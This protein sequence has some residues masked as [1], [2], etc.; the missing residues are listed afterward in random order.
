MHFSKKFSVSFAC[1]NCS[2]VFGKRVFLKKHN[3]EVHGGTFTFDCLVCN[4][5][6]ASRPE[7]TSHIKHCEAERKLKTFFETGHTCR[8]CGN[9]MPTIDALVSHFEN[10]HPELKPFQCFKCGDEFST[11]EVMKFHDCNKSCICDTCGKE[12]ANKSLL[13]RHHDR[14][15]DKLKRNKRFTCTHCDKEFRW[16]NSLIL[17]MMNHEGTKPSKLKSSLKKS[18]LIKSS[19][20]IIIKTSKHQN[21]KT[22]PS[23]TG[24]LLPESWHV[25][26]IR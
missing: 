23:K 3:I 2:K 25:S 18:S 22:K 21:I 1:N 13:A 9:T 4:K 6:F 16:K 11:K 24:W 17:H 8:I 19:S 15:H 7:L 14:Y 10:D 12:L 20:K 5:E 26:K